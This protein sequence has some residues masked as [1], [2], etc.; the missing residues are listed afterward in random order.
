MQRQAL[1]QDVH[2]DD[3]RVGLVD[4]FDKR[5]AVVSSCSFGSLFHSSKGRSL[6]G[7]S[8]R[9]SG[10]WSPLRSTLVLVFLIAIACGTLALRSA[11]V[12]EPGRFVVMSSSSVTIAANGE[13]LYRRG[14]GGRGF[15]VA[16][17]SSIGGSLLD[18]ARNFDTWGQ[19]DSARLALVERTLQAS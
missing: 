3:A 14:G 12:G 7:L 13:V 6:N 16:A 11:T 5:G 15:N 4:Q 19:G 18:S 10:T 1:C 9:C 17:F 2:Y 8:P